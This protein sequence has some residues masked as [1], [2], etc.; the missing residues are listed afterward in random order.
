MYQSVD[1]LLACEIRA[2]ILMFWF[3]KRDFRTSVL[4]SLGLRVLLRLLHRSS[5]VRICFLM[6]LSID[7]YHC[8]ALD[9]NH[10][11][12]L[13]PCVLPSI[14]SQEHGL[15]SGLLH[16]TN[17]MNILKRMPS[18]FNRALHHRGELSLAP[19][20]SATQKGLVLSL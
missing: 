16:S 17:H 5:S 13:S 18:L 14:T 2:H 4:L 9:T 3:L 1:L 19:S 10:Q 6:R 7:N 11:I 12:N 8:P 15:A 20:A